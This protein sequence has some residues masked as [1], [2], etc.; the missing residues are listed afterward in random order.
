MRSFYDTRTGWWWS[1]SKLQQSVPVNAE[2]WTPVQTVRA[3]I[4][5]GTNHK[6]FSDEK[7]HLTCNLKL[8]WLKNLVILLIKKLNSSFNDEKILINYSEIQH[9]LRGLLLI[10]FK[11]DWHFF[12]NFTTLIFKYCKSSWNSS[13]WRMKSGLI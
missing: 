4:S 11:C 8:L 2:R 10:K 13:S 9:Y 5:T 7:F 3:S 12:Q 1:I 6:K